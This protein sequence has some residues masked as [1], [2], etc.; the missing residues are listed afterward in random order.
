[1]E[2]L[3]GCMTDPTRL[4]IG[5]LFKNEDFDAEELAIMF[6]TNLI[7]VMRCITEYETEFHGE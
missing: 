7:K 6:N 5:W 3:A 2:R 4:Q 1:M